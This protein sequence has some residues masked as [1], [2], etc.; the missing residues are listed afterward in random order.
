RRLDYS[1]PQ[2]TIQARFVEVS[3]ESTNLIDDI[4]LIPI[5][6]DT[7]GP[8]LA[9]LTAPQFRAVLHALEQRNGADVISESSVTTLSG[10][11]AQVQNVDAQSIVKLNPQVLVP[12][13]ASNAYVAVP[14]FS[15]PVLDIIPFVSEAGDKIQLTVT[16]KVT[17]FLGYDAPKKDEA[18]PVYLN[19]KVT[20][21]QP[22]HPRTHARSMQTAA[23]LIYDGQT[24][25]LGR[26][27]DEMITY[28]PAGKALS[29]PSTSKKNLLVFVT[30]TLIDAAGNPVHSLDSPS[31]PPQR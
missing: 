8:V 13:G 16:A 18:V 1:P 31:S 6:S 2:V 15:G 7:N 20:T 4:N 30:A 24:V 27:K 25:V 23:A 17:E 9:V 14:L 22:P 19:G 11:Q 21:I 10:R 26:P 5:N 28:G 29:A 12:P 3:E